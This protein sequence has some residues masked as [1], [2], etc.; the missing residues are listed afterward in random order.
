MRLYFQEEDKAKR[1]HIVDIPEEDISLEG[2]FIEGSGKEFVITG[3]AVIEGERYHNFEIAF[4]LD[5]E[6][7]QLTVEGIMALDWQWYDFVF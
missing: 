2:E 1:L 5:E 7:A 6:P 3:I 4:G